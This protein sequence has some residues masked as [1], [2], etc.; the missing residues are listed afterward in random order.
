MGKTL[1]EYCIETGNHVLLEQWHP[2]KNAGLTPHD[3]MPGSHKKIHWCCADG[4][5][6]QAAAY[7]RT[8]GHGCP[9][10][11]RE[12][13][14]LSQTLEEKAPHL[15]KEWHPTKNQDITPNNVAPYTVRRVWWKCEKGHEWRAVIKDRANGAGCPVCANRVIIAGENDL[16]TTHPEIAVE[17]HPELNGELTPQMVSWGSRRKVWWVCKKGHEWQAVIQSRTLNQH[18]CPICAG[19]IVLPGENDFASAFP[20]IAAQ[21]HPTKNGSLHPQDVTPYSNKAIWWLC[22]RGHEYQASVSHRTSVKSGCPYC[23]NRKV[24]VGFNDLATTQPKIAAQWHPELNGELT[25]QMVPSGSRRAVWWIC[26]EG[27]VWNA[28]IQSRTG[29]RKHGCPVCSGHVS[30]KRQ[31]RYEE[32]VKA[33]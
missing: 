7:V 2:T 6:W 10:C 23:A 27:H 17:W 18:G 9:V 1:Y 25:P 16:A 29:K 8:A 13:R 5:E 14:P 32:M 21:W 15:V 11:A 3:V 12:K 33:K 28:R 20:E 30:E 31:A 26:A 22:E 4:H 24:L 19:K